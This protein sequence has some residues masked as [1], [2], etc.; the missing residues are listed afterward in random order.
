M[1]ICMVLVTANQACFDLMHCMIGPLT[2]LDRAF[3]K[4]DPTHLHSV[5]IHT[6]E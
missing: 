1:A 2:Q 6:F 4:L 3:F 5:V